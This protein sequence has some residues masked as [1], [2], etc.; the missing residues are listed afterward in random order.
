MPAR[1]APR[2]AAHCLSA[3]R[4]PGNPTPRWHVSGRSCL[5]CP[6]TV[7]WLATLR[8]RPS[9]QFI[10]APRSTSTT[11]IKCPL[12]HP[13]KEEALRTPDN[14]LVFFLQQIAPEQLLSGFPLRAV[15]LPRVTGNRDTRLSAASPAQALLA[16]APEN[17]L[18]WPTVGREAFKRLAAVIRRTPRFYLEAGTD[19]KQIPDA[20]DTAIRGSAVIPP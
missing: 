11:F 4:A 2:R 13:H 9:A 17:V 3:G 6:T 16:L 1:W 7:A 19:L 12:L 10:A 14:K 5:T 18:R 15:L 20:I 8:R